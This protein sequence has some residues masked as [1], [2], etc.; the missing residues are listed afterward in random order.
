MELVSP[1]MDFVF[2]ELMEDAEVRRYFISDVLDMPVEEIA[3]TRLGNPFLR[4]HLQRQKQGILDVK[5]FLLNGTRINIELQVRRQ[6]FW[7]KRTL[8]YLAK[9]FVDVLFLGDNFD[10]LRRCI[11]INILDFNLIAGNEYHTIYRMRD[12]RGVDFSDLLELHTIELRKVLHGDTR[13]DDWIRLFNA[14]TQEELDMIRTKNAGIERA[15]YVMQEM[16]LS[17]SV[18]EVVTAYRKKKLDR[19]LED[20]YVYDQG[21]QQLLYELVSEGKIDMDTA[22]EKSGLTRQEFEEKMIDAGYHLKSV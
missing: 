5:V 6:K 4:R 13:V 1:K 2:R 12:E 20:A 8:Y 21:Q 16:S 14:K 17:E 10:K 19:K 18:R 22:V 3:Q 11:A 7:N 15:K 9:M